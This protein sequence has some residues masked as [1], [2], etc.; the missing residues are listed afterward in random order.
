MQTQKAELGQFHEF[1]SL[2]NKIKTYGKGRLVRVKANVKKNPLKRSRSPKRTIQAKSG[3]KYSKS[4][5]S[6]KA[7]GNTYRKHG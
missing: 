6:Q 2:T 3:E 5:K 4:P 1:K 7:Q